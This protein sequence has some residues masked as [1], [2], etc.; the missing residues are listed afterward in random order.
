MLFA[1]VAQAQAMDEAWQQAAVVEKNI[2][3]LC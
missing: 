1:V 2:A 3:V